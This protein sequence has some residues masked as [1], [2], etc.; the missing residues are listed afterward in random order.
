MLENKGSSQQADE[1]LNTKN[2]LCSY[3]TEQAPRYLILFKLPRSE[4]ADSSS[5]RKCK[6]LLFHFSRSTSLI[7]EGIMKKR[8]GLSF[9][10]TLTLL[11][12]WPL[13]RLLGPQILSLGKARQR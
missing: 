13:T 12:E 9:T 5:A 11:E 3:K 2:S 10:N 1:V 6:R 7:K 8:E 4:P